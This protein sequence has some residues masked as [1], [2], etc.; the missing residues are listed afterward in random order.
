MSSKP[1]PAPG[2]TSRARERRLQVLA[3]KLF[4]PPGLGTFVILD[5]ARVDGLL[6][7]IGT[8][9]VPSA[10]LFAGKLEPSVARTAPYL[11]QLQQDSNFVAWLLERGWGRSWGVFARFS[12]GLNELRKHLRRLLLVKGPDGKTMFFRFYDPRV[13]RLYL[14]TCNAEELATVFGPVQAYVMES[15][16]ARDVQSFLPGTAPVRLETS[17]LPSAES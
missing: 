11:V 14:P 6:R 15:E 8:H 3:A 12:G 4:D 10:C 7:A 17:S 5:G 9:N 13:L 16:D 1:N 2:T